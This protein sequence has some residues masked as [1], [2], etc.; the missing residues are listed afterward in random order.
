VLGFAGP[1]KEAFLIVQYITQFLMNLSLEV[2]IDKTNFTHHSKGILFLGYH[3]RGDYILNHLTSPINYSKP[4]VLYFN[5]Q[6]TVPKKK[7]LQCYKNQGYFR[8]A[9]K[10]KNKNRLVAKK[11]DN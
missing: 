1:K 9:K 2:S 4:R 8:I 6:F 7:I 5:L 10:G 11:M 3:I